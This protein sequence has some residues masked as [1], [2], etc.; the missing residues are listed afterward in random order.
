MNSKHKLKLNTI[1]R[2]EDDFRSKIST[3]IGKVEVYFQPFS[4][5][6]FKEFKHDKVAG[7]G[8]Y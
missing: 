2:G 4:Q 1:W 7:E 8:Q 3:T 6:A 5:V